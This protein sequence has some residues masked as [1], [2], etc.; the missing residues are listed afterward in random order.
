MCGV[1]DRADVLTVTAATFEVLVVII[2]FADVVVAAA[3]VMAMRRDISFGGNG[4]PCS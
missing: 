1:T 2:A 4:S 3:K